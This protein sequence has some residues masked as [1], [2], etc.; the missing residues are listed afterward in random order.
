VVSRSHTYD[1]WIEKVYYLDKES[2]FILRMDGYLLDGGERWLLYKAVVDYGFIPLEDGY[3]DPVALGDFIDE[4]PELFY[5]FERLDRE[6]KTY[7]LSIDEYFNEGI[8][9]NLR[10]LILV[11]VLDFDEDFAMQ[12]QTLR[13]KA[14]DGD[15]TFVFTF[16][17]DFVYVWSP[18]LTG[19]F[20]VTTSE[21]REYLNRLLEIIYSFD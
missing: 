18:V 15:V 17:S 20:E 7:G 1:G 21:T 4:A 14:S 11:P 8:L 2:G 9:E 12:F 5:A 3:F 10:E 13:A 6:D 19:G 16:R